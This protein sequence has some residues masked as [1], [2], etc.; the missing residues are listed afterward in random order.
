MKVTAAPKMGNQCSGA[1]NNNN[2]RSK[3]VVT[4]PVSTSNNA[5][6]F[7]AKLTTVEHNLLKAHRGCFHCKQFYVNHCSADCPL[8][9]NGH[10]TLDACK[11]VTIT[12]AL[13]AKATYK[14]AEG[15]TLAVAAVFAEDSNGSFEMAEDEATEY[16]PQ[17][18]SLPSH[19]WWECCIDAPLTCAPTP[20]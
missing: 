1:G 11:K 10:P 9:K 2:N 16:I 8:G 20:I 3:E 12:E 15:T 4:N 13:K 14:K 5:M 17:L 6:A 7:I 19:L 18:F